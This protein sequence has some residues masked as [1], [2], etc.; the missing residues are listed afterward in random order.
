ML[1]GYL[2]AARYVAGCLQA[3]LRAARRG[4]SQAGALSLEWVIIAVGIAVIAG[5]AVVAFTA[6]VNKQTA[7]LP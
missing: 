1:D 7:N 4:D 2:N 6:A 5:V 3:R